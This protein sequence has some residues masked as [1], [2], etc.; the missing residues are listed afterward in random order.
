MYVQYVFCTHMTNASRYT[1]RLGALTLISCSLLT[2]TFRL[3]LSRR[4]GPFQSLRRT[5]KSFPP[6]SSSRVLVAVYTVRMKDGWTEDVRKGLVLPQN[7][8]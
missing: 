6:L 7:I 1:G 3:L 8:G 2:L 5:E 4:R